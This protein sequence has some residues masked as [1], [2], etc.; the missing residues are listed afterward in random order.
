MAIKRVVD[1]NARVRVKPDKSGVELANVKMSV[2]PFCEIALEEAVRLKEKKIADEVVAVSIGSRACQDQLRQALAI[3]ADRGIH[4]ASERPDIQPLSVAKVLAVL[5]EREKPGLFMLGKQAIDDDC[6]QTGQML[7]AILGWPQ[8][9]QAYKLDVQPDKQ[10]VHVT[11]EVDG[12]LETLALKLPAVITTDLRLNQPRYATLPNIM[13]AKKKP[14]EQTSAEMLRVG[15]IPKLE[16]V[17]VE[18]PPPRKGGVIVSSVEE[19]VQKLK[20]EAK[21]L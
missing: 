12:G 10:S 7:A 2:N 17:K 3:G 15:L 8:A 9:C 19:L 6:S 16:T 5:A 20:H 14:M 4:V 13:K 11:R 21:V 1:Y 18:P